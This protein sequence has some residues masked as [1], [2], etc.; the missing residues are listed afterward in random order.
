QKSPWALWVGAVPGAMPPLMGWTAAMNTLEAPGLLLFGILFTWQIA[1][2]LAIAI[3]RK[4]EYRSAGIRVLPVVSGDRPAKFHIVY[5]PFAL[6]VFSLLLA[7]VG[8]LG[9][10]YTST[11]LVG[12]IVFLLRT[13]VGIPDPV[14]E[15]W[16]RGVFVSPLVYLT[17][18]FAAL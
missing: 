13:L 18:V 12:G 7:G 17:A 15:F 3:V 14:A 11:A 1:H 6:L 8:R 16:A 9:L 5:A 4:E 10:L 2:F